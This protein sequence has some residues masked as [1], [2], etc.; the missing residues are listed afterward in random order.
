MLRIV[1]KI[2]GDKYKVL[3]SVMLPHGDSAV[4]FVYKFILGS[5]YKDIKRTS[6]GKIACYSMVSALFIRLNYDECIHMRA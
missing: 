5:G 1:S 6:T 3:S 2:N 4:R